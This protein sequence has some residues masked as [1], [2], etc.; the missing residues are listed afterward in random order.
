MKFPIRRFSSRWSTLLGVALGLVGAVLL[1]WG[2]WGAAI[3]QAD[4]GLDGALILER[5]HVS[6]DGYELFEVSPAGG[7]SSSSRAESISRN[8]DR[9]LNNRL[10][11]DDSV[12]VTV[13]QGG[14]AV[15]LR[16]NGKYIM[17]VTNGDRTPE[18][19]STLDQGELWREAIA[20]KLDRAIED[21]Q[22]VNLL[23]SAIAMVIAMGIAGGCHLGLAWL[24][25]DQRRQNLRRNS[26]GRNIPGRN[27]PGR[28]SPGRHDLDSAD[29]ADRRKGQGAK[30]GAT[31]PPPRYSILGVSQARQ[32]PPRRSLLLLLIGV[33]QV[34][35]WV[36]AVGYSAQL[37]PP[38][39]RLLYWIYGLA[40]AILSANLLRLGDSDVSLLDVG[41]LLVF[42]ALWWFVV[43]W[44]AGVFNRHILPLTGIDP[45][46]K[47]AMSSYAQ[48]MLLG[49][50][51][52]IIVSVVGLD[53]GAIAIILGGFG[54]GIGFGLQNIAKDFISG[55]IM[56]VERP[57]KVGEMV[58]V[59]DTTGWVKHIGPR[60]T[61]LSHLDRYLIR[62]P[63]SQF[64]DGAVSNF[65]RSGVFRLKIDVGIAYGSDVMLVRDLLL[66]AALEPHP[67]ILRHP[68]PDVLFLSWDD[69]AIL[70]QLIVFIREPTKGPRLEALLRE[71]VHANLDK[72]DIQIPFPQR[73]LNLNLPHLDEA[74]EA[75][76]GDRAQTVAP[77]PKVVIERP[78][79]NMGVD[80]DALVRD[81]RSSEGV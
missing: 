66:A 2:W 20:E 71:R 32:E 8:L 15:V 7:F 43:H 65:R 81:M 48:Y 53:L 38:T 16:V 57:V 28:N 42:V 73:D 56:L 3:A 45:T 36:L 13:D 23:Y 49:L 62:V 80:W 33:V 17:T 64:V 6:V 4:A 44:F 14:G 37:F 78:R 12:N 27:I 76:L 61:E 75:W 22:P 30:A 39:R 59:G 21:R 50:G 47:A 69:N 29:N 55:I 1:G 58:Q 25:R 60:F 68:N 46:L 40:K 41:G 10:G 26:L 5:S 54:V 79:V 24:G 18:A 51:V 9:E 52:L 19:E 72:Y 74:V 35:I 70:L 31:P 67:E 34:S 11:S 63:N 77:E